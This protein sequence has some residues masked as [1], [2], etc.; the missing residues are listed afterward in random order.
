MLIEAHPGSQTVR[1]RRAVYSA[2]LL[3][4]MSTVLAGAH[5]WARSGPRLGA[6]VRPE[7]WSASFR[8]PGGFRVQRSHGNSSGV[9]Y[10]GYL[11]SGAGADLFFNSRDVGP[12]ENAADVGRHALADLLLQLT[13]G[14]SA[15]I[16]PL[17]SAALI[18]GVAG[19]EFGVLEPG[20]LV[21]SVVLE[22]GDAYILT[23]VGGRQVP[24]KVG[25]TR[26]GEP[27]KA[28]PEFEEL[29]RVWSDDPDFKA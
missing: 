14:R 16:T 10:R 8:P 3:F 26:T 24:F 6:L 22:S 7:G 4:V 18:G 12:H 28:K 25:R 11:P 1:P 5:T 23:L 29:R 19:V 13:G 2:A 17:Q 27:I 20:I 15:A 9:H 21:R